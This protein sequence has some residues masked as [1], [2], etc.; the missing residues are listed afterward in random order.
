MIVIA[1]EEECFS[2][3]NITSC[4]GTKEKLSRCSR[5]H[6]IIEA[7]ELRDHLHIHDSLEAGYTSGDVTRVYCH[8]NFV[9]IYVS[10]QNL[11]HLY[12]KS[13]PHSTSKSQTKRLRDENKGKKFEFN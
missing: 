8:K 7:N 3:G 12:Q 11:A 10:P 13:K 9:S 4:S 6:K 5:I 2:T 1:T